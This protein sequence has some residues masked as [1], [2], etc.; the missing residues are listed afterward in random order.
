MEKTILG[1]LKVLLATFLT[2]Y[3]WVILYPYE[4]EKLT[5][6]DFFYLFRKASQLTQTEFEE[7][8]GVIGTDIPELPN[9][10]ID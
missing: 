6:L 5:P 9:I 2:S 8:F 4:T 1:I 3:I 7:S 10:D